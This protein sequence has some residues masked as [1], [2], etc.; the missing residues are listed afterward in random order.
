MKVEVG[1]KY[2]LVKDFNIV[3]TNVTVY[4]E[5]RAFQGKTVTV[6]YI[7]TY[8][9][10]RFDVVEDDQK[11]WYNASMIECEVKEEM[12]HKQL[13]ERIAEIEAELEEKKK[14]LEKVDF[15]KELEKYYFVSSG[16]KVEID[17]FWGSM[18]V[19]SLRKEIGNC[20]R[21]KEEAEAMAEK[22]KKLL[23]GEE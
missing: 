20:F 13:R 10:N 11:Y 17:E 22:I 2:R 16:A 1:K 7:S 12:N 5:M 6:A 3:D 21:T 23:K 4:D 14:L 18:E 8:T 15:P 9:D 19:D